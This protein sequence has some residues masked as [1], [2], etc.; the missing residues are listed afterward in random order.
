MRLIVKSIRESPFLIEVDETMI[1]SDIKNRIYTITGIPPCRQQVVLRGNVLPNSLKVS[2]LR[3]SDMGVIYFCGRK[4]PRRPPPRPK[5]LFPKRP[6]SPASRRLVYDH[7]VKSLPPQ[8]LHFAQLLQNMEDDDLTLSSDPA[9][10]LATLTCI[11]RV[12]N[13]I[14]SRPDGLRLLATRLD[15]VNQLS[16]QMFP[17]DSTQPLTVLPSPPSSPSTEPLPLLLPFGGGHSRLNT[18]LQAFCLAKPQAPELDE[19]SKRSGLSLLKLFLEFITTEN[20]ESEKPIKDQFDLDK[21]EKQPVFP[22]IFHSKKKEDNVR[23]SDRDL[24]HF[25]ID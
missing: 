10:R 18:A 1:V 21:T 6:L 19:G 12:M 14:E 16:E 8:H 25:D 9:Q 13:I 11:D 15:T 24:S 7:F 23:Q 3:L 4:P 20:E 17:K 5:T 2:I 22:Q